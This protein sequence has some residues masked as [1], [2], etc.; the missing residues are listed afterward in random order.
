MEVL[1]RAA[2]GRLADLLGPDYLTMDY[3][4][5]RDSETDAERAQ[6]VAAQ[7]TAGQRVSLQAYAVKPKPPDITHALLRGNPGQKGA[8]VTPG[9]VAA[10]GAK[11]D[12]GLSADAPDAE[13]RRKMAVLATCIVGVVVLMGLT[14]LGARTLNERIGTQ[15]EYWS[16]ASSER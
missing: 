14:F 16:A 8:P 11:A 5:R 2:E 15:R 1:R 9:G 12:F 13:R 3:V 6:A 7:L 4:T 10:A